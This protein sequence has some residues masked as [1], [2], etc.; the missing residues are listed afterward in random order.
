[1]TETKSVVC[2]ICGCLCDDLEVTVENNKITKVNN[3]CAVCKAKFVYGYCSEDRLLKP[4][5][6]KD[7]K[8]VPVT[9]DEAIHAA[10]KILTDAKYPLL[11][12][13]TSS[14][15]EAQRLGVQ[16]AE[17]V[18]STLDNSSSIC[19]GP[20]V[21]A[22]QEMGLPSCTLG[23]VRHRADL[24]V[25]WGAN[26]RASHPRHLDRYT[27][28]TDGRFEKSARPEYMKR[29]KE[30]ACIKQSQS[31]AD[32]VPIDGE[33]PSWQT[34]GRKLIVFD[35]RKT[36]TADAADCYIQVQQNKDYEV[37][38]ALRALVTD[39]EV[40]VDVVGGVPVKAL[41]EVAD[42][43]INCKF[44]AIF[45]GL[46]LTNSLGKFRNVE[47]AIGL[48]RDLNKRTKFTITP[49]RGH[50]NV[51]G[52]NVVFT[53]QSGYPLGLDFS[54]GYPQYNPGEY[55]AVDLLR[56][57]DNDAT[58]VISTDAGAHLPKPSVQSMVKKPL[59]VID[60]AMSCTAMLGDVVIPTQW[61]GIEYAGTSY[62]MDHVPI[63]L[64]KV[65]DAPEG[66]L[67]DE[68]ILTRI[69]NEV[70]KIRQQ[71]AEENS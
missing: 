14:T 40:D 29:K 3:G 39:Q 35:V 38:A 68:Q 36:L 13:W 23:Q 28:F 43:M 32:N 19:H 62:R 71:N 57:G 8:L 69:I 70:K 24:I 66:I 44:G 2:S 31:A 30:R 59:I 48:V 5:I 63:M 10:A 21:M 47:M 16:L 51:T 6:R 50:F 4:M 65:V 34:E 18:G 17:E 42:A 53:Y 15:G 9:M 26:P 58:L 52:A 67:N 54:Q 61:C 49:M 11:F 1:M 37:M 41:E 22:M 60:P 55:T 20:S 25:Y 27:I 12:G 33:V 64:K 56:R 45:Y 46:G 7:G